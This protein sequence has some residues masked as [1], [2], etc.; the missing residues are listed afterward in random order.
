MSK[1]G[2]FLIVLSA[3]LIVCAF[4]VPP[5]ALHAAVSG[6]LQTPRLS[7][8][9]AY[10]LAPAENTVEKLSAFTDRSVL[11]VALEPEAT[12]EQ[13]APRLRQELNS[14]QELHAIGQELC[15]ALNAGTYEELGIE[16]IC[17]VQPEGLLL[18]EVYRLNLPSVGAEAVMDAATGRILNLSMYDPRFFGTEHGDTIG[19][20]ELEGWA[21]YFGLT[22][23]ESTAAALSPDSQQR[24]ESPYARIIVAVLKQARLTDDS[25]SSVQFGLQYEYTSGMNERCIWGPCG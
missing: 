16:R 21:E 2:L 19:M 15:R 23:Q 13:L 14:L 18:F 10:T 22:A 9:S 7:D 12:T 25:G 17:M 24:R 1:R 11:T 5:L 6:S 8:A 20:R 4:L 3:V